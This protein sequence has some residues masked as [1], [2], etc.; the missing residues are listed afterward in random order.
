M[1]G[2]EERAAEALGGV[3]AAADGEAGGQGGVVAAM[4]MAAAATEAAALQGMVTGMEG[5]EV[6]TA[7]LLAP[8]E[9]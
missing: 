4:A 9:A 8:G 2:E 6:G 7:S 3:T 1:A 5:E